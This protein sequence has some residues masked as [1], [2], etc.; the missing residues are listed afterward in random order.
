MCLIDSDKDIL[1]MLK[2]TKIIGGIKIYLQH[3][4]DEAEHVRVSENV[5]GH[6]ENESESDSDDEY[7]SQSESD[8]ANLDN[9]SNGEEEELIEVRKQCIN[10]KAKKNN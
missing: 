5:E 8:V 6:A 10:R 2:Y 7:E 4:S 3:A 9:V 1:G